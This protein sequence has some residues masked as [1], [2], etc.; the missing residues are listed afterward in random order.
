VSKNPE[1]MTQKEYEAWRR[2]QGARPF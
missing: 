2:Q 1:N